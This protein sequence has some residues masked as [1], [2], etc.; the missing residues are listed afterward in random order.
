MRRRLP[1]FRWV[2]LLTTALLATTAALLLL[3]R[4]RRVVEARGALAGGTIAVRAPWEGRVAEVLVQPG[5]PVRTGDPLLRLEAGPLAADLEQ[6]RVR[7]E[8]L[9]DQS[10]AAMRET[11]RLRLEA[12]PREREQAELAVERAQLELEQAEH[13]ET[14]FRTAYEKGVAARE[15]LYEAETARRLAE[16]ALRDARAALPATLSRQTGELEQLEAQARALA[17]RT[18]EERSMLREREREHSEATLRAEADGVVAETDLSTLVG[19]AV[20]TGDELLRIASGVPGRFEGSVTDNGR[21][22]VR[23]GQSVK[24]RMDAYPW[25]LHGS[26]AGRV[27]LVAE[28][29]ESGGGYRVEI[30]CDP[31]TAPGELHDG[32]SGKA[33]I[34]VEEKTSLARLLLER[35]VGTRKR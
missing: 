15:Q 31:S 4:V 35:L 13:H 29:P 2:I 24:I 26:L 18:E 22:R 33:R 34:M 21:A 10:A 1:L 11:R 16:V 20:E 7:I 30:A 6:I 19:Q 12:H 28:R 3:V 25:I 23:P 9:V 5:R 14:I 27:A 32:L 8:S 17:A